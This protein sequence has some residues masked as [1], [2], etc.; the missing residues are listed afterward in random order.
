MNNLT[1]DIAQRLRTRSVIG[2]LLPLPVTALCLLNGHDFLFILPVAASLLCAAEYF[3]LHRTNSINQRLL[4]TRIVDMS[5]WMS[6]AISVFTII[7]LVSYAVRFLSYLGPLSTHISLGAFEGNCLLFMVSIMSLITSV[8]S[9]IENFSIKDSLFA[10]NQ[11]GDIFLEI[12]KKVDSIE[13][14]WSVV[15]AHRD[16]EGFARLYKRDWVSPHALYRPHG[17]VLWNVWRAKFGDRPYQPYTVFAEDADNAKQIASYKGAGE[18]KLL[19]AR[20]IETALERA[21]QRK[22]AEEVLEKAKREEEEREAAS[23]AKMQNRFAIEDE[24]RLA[25]SAPSSSDALHQQFYEAIGDI[26]D[27]I[28][29]DS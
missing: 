8:P 28:Q 4:R 11:S 14:A 21:A 10:E 16:N 24:K 9:A 27:P 29:S 17:T 20:P 15:E 12:N 19:V 26:L 5:S 13:D 7:L 23:A 1:K 25:L 3:N 6:L 22:R 2:T 18:E